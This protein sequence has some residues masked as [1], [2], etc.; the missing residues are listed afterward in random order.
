M[1]NRTSIRRTD[2]TTRFKELA[3]GD[4]FRSWAWGVEWLLKK[5][6]ATKAAIVISD[7]KSGVLGV[8]PDERVTLIVCTPR[9]TLDETVD[10]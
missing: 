6:S 10:S 3:V 7:E 4:H 1:I 8:G 2:K 5:L 9:Y